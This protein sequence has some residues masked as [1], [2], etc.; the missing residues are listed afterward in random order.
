[1]SKLDDFLMD[2][3]A[4]SPRTRKGTFCV[5]L[6]MGLQCR[7]V[8]GILHIRDPEPARSRCLV[9][10]FVLT[11]GRSDLVICYSICGPH[12]DRHTKAVMKGPSETRYLGGFE[13]VLPDGTIIGIGL[14]PC[15][16][17]SSRLRYQSHGQLIYSGH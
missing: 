9:F 12:N 17:M 11:R 6:G 2:L 5:H 16:L 3:I 13:S 4:A 7:L 10:D 8:N 15:H 1:M 14:G